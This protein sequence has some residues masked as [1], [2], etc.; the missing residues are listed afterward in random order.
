MRRNPRISRLGEIA[1]PGAANVA[2]IARWL[3]PPTH[4]GGRDDDHRSL[5]LELLLTLILIGILSLDR[6]ITPRSAASPSAPMTSTISS[7]R[8][9]RPLSAAATSAL[10]WV[11]V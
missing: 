10:L 11:V 5:I 3:E 8:S 1:R 4:F 7:F 2:A 9:L 6:L